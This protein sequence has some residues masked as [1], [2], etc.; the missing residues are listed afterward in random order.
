MLIDYHSHTGHSRCVKHPYSV[1]DGF[2]M[3]KSRGIDRWGVTNHVHFNSPIQDFFQDLKAEINAVDPKNIYLGLELDI[4]S[5]DGHCVLKPETIKLVDYIIAAPHN[6]AIGF[7]TMPD[8]DEDGVR[9]YFIALKKTLINSFKKI[10]IGI[11][12]HPFL[13][14]VENF[15]AKYWKP[16]LRPM[17]NDLLPICASKGIAVEINES[18]FSKTS[19]V[20]KHEEII[21]GMHYTEQVTSVLQDLYT[22]VKG[23]SDVKLSY[24]SDA[25]SVEDAGNIGDLIKFAK[26]LGIP[27]SRFVVIE[28]K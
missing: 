23:H 13:Q 21:D 1:K 26:K 18:Y 2:K 20:D 15:G 22:M 12:A 5:E 8:T 19:N 25:H 4:D 11:W 6:Q 9:E 10:P 17:L 14:E 16:Y 7:L 28:K 3:A 24:G 27:D